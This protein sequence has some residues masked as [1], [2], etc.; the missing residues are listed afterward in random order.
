MGQTLRALPAGLAARSQ[1]VERGPMVPRAVV[2][3]PTRNELPTIAEIIAR[4]L[5][6]QRH[7]SPIELHVLVV[8]G[9]STDGTTEY[10]TY[11]SQQDPRVHVIVVPEPGLGTALLTAHR[12]AIDNLK[13]TMIAQMDADLSHS[14]DVIPALLMPLTH[15]ADLTI[16]SRYVP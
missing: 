2:V 10:A 16:G 7:V 8:D 1:P 6:Q 5:D 11:A 14:P 4:V 9:A 12:Y 15:S 13:A 3:I